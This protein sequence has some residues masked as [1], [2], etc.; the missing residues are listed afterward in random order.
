MIYC[1]IYYYVI[2]QIK[3]LFEL[4]TERWKNIA[5]LKKKKKRKRRNINTPR[6]RTYSLVAILATRTEKN[7]PNQIGTQLVESI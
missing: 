3:Y 6:N 4:T 5:N 1:K 2:T 7:K